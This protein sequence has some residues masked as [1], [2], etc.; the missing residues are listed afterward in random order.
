[1]KHLLRSLSPFAYSRRAVVSFGKDC[2]QVL[3]IAP[4]RTKPAHE[5]CGLEPVH[6]KCGLVN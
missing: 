6:E 5:K 3:V 1:M 2:S 4:L